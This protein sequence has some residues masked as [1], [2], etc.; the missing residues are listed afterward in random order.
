MFI[1]FKVSREIANK[2]R[3]ISWKSEKEKKLKLDQMKSSYDAELL[4]NNHTQTNLRIS[5]RIGFKP[6]SY[7]MYCWT[8]NRYISICSIIVLILIYVV[9]FPAFECHIHMIPE[10]EPQNYRS[11]CARI[12]VY[13]SVLYCQRAFH[14]HERHKYTIYIPFN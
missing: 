12:S 13:I 10:P 4:K 14:I 1:R 6:Q 11:L 9:R 7:T 8:W 2:T 5:C 3:R